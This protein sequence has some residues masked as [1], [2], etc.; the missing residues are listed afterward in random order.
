MTERDW[1]V[2]LPRPDGGL[3]YVVFIAPYS[4]FNRFRSTYERMLQTLQL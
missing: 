3:L 2:T 4:E 1:L